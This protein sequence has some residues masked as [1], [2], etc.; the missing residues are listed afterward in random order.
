MG[1]SIA[2]MMTRI[3]VHFAHECDHDHEEKVKNKKLSLEEKTVKD[4]KEL[5]IPVVALD[6]IQSPYNIFEPTEEDYRNYIVRFLIKKKEH[7]R[8]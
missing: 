1:N 3:R 6:S 2:K 7:S 5:D 4:L 8:Q